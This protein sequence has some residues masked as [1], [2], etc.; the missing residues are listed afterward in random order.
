MSS[1]NSSKSPGSTAN[2]GLGNFR[3]DLTTENHDVEPI[4]VD[5]RKAAETAYDQET[6]TLDD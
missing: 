4:D 3:E 5:H 6:E 1:S 2:R